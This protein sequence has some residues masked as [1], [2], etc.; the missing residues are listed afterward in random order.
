MVLGLSGQVPCDED[1][2]DERRGVLQQSRGRVLVAADPAAPAAAT[3]GGG[4]S[5]SKSQA[6][7][8]GGERKSSDDSDQNELSDPSVVRGAPS[9]GSAAML[10]IESDSQRSPTVDAPGSW[11]PAGLL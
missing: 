8:G 11:S 1:K 5:E 4:H 10:G 9:H 2:E 7:P 6:E 3:H